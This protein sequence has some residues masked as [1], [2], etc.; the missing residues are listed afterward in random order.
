MNGFNKLGHR[1]G[2][3]PYNGISRL[4]RSSYTATTTGTRGNS[5]NETLKRA[6]GNLQTDEQL[7]GN[8]SSRSDWSDKD[9]QTVA[10]SKESK[11]R[12]KFFKRLFKTKKLPSAPYDKE[13][14]IKEE[15]KG[16]KIAKKLIKTKLQK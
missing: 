10:S 8:S 1:V 12:W 11:H 7:L 15:S 14:S 9:L 5:I 13:R 6:Q 4:S 3:I 2:S 16:N